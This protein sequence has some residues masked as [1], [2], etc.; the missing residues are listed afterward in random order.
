V[1]R[2]GVTGHRDLS[3]ADPEILRA[4]IA[5]IFEMIASSVQAV[6]MHSDAPAIYSKEAPAVLLISALAIGADTLAAELALERK[7]HLA[8]AMPFF[9]E[10]YERDFVKEAAPAF[11]AMLE[12]ARAEGAVV[13][14]DNDDP[15]QRPQGYLQSGR[16]MLRHCDLMLAIWNGGPSAGVGGTGDVIAEARAMNIP[17]VKVDPKNSRQIAFLSRNEEVVPRAPEVSATIQETVKTILWPPLPESAVEAAARFFVHEERAGEKNP[18]T[19]ADAKTA[20]ITRWIRSALLQLGRASRAVPKTESEGSEMPSENSFLFAH[21]QRADRLATAYS[22]VHRGNFIV[23]SVFGAF[24]HV[25]G[26]AAL[27]MASITSHDSWWKFGF[28]A[29][30]LAFLAAL[31]FILWS[32][33]RVQRRERWLDYRLLAEMLRE[34]SLLT[35]IGRGHSFDG[36]LKLEADLNP[37]SRWVPRAYRAIIR[38]AGVTS[39]KY[40]K[41]YLE[42]VREYAA[43]NRLT[44][45][46]RY[47]EANA[48]R[49][50]LLNDRLR[51]VSQGLFAL[52]LFIVVIEL[53]PEESAPHVVLK[54][55]G[56]A[57][58]AA[59][60]PAFAYA[61]FAIRS[62]NEFEILARSSA[63]MKV[64]FER[65]RDRIWALRGASL[66]SITLGDELVRAAETM[67]NE[68]ADW[69]G[70]FQTKEVEAA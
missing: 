13:E 34:A 11:K 69:I 30:E 59:A 25:C 44:H 47:H 27:Y 60:L 63:R 20:P 21:F 33:R 9:E 45:H 29:S 4:T 2:V 56:G 24:A 39:A 23:V 8:V 64:Q 62:Q 68:V 18:A 7:W 35:L 66:T 32:D 12:R 16:F 19:K 61:L 14:L 50:R 46:I 40:D 42:K 41:A 36:S 67:R 26:V 3:D 54:Y 15:Q 58:L 70:I 57:A 53:L 65:H 55:V 1:L 6:Q 22:E 43:A 31:S 48:S 28:V 49:M 10:A 51:A 38:A 5:E 52:T 37:R 17:I